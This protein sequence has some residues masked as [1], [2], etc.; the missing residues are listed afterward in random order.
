MP[1]S[2]PLTTPIELK[3]GRTIATL[4]EVREM[5]LSIPLHVRRGD[6]WRY[7]AELLD[8][9]A[10]DKAAVT[11]VEEMLVRGLTAARMI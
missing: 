4:A 2:R 11:E 10:N 8:E 5:M 9:A 3:D 1:W 6:V 7:A